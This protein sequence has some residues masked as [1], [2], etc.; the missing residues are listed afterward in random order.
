MKFLSSR[1][2]EPDISTPLSKCENDAPPPRLDRMAP[3]TNIPPTPCI[4]KMEDRHGLSTRLF[5]GRVQRLCPNACVVVASGK[6]IQQVAIGRPPGP[7]IGTGVWY[8]D[9]F[10]FPGGF[11]IPHRRDFQRLTD[12]AW[13]MKR[14]PLTVAR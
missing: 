2:R 3:R 6:K 10:C 7:A 14:Q 9:P 1:F 8:R 4:V 12:W 5:C 11:A 13:Q